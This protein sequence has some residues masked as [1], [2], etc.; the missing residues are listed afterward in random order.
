[1]EKEKARREALH[2]EIASPPAGSVFLLILTVLT[3]YMV[4]YIYPKRQTMPR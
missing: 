4:H 2:Q 1:M 3:F